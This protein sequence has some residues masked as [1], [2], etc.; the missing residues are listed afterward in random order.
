MHVVVAFVI[1][2]IAYVCNEQFATNTRCISIHRWVYTQPFF[3][4]VSMNLCKRVV[5]FMCIDFVVV[6]I[7]GS[8]CVRT[9]S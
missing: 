7:A 1:V 3:T 4:A 8:V 9:N 2:I 5:F 6:V